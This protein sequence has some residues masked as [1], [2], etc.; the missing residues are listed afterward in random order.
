MRYY[1]ELIYDF[2]CDYSMDID[3]ILDAYN[4]PNIN[5]TGN[6]NVLYWVSIIDSDI[7]EFE[8]FYN[9]LKNKELTFTKPQLDFILD[10]TNIQHKLELWNL[11]KFKEFLL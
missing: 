10:S 9:L 1:M 2:D 6:E 5:T 11:N 3:D 8:N 7:F 4:I